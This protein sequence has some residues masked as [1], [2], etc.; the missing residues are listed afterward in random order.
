MGV[1]VIPLV[2]SK[3]DS[4]KQ[5]GKELK[6]DR[7]KELKDLNKR[8]GLKRHAA[9]LTETPNGP[10]AVVLHEG[11]GADTFL[12]KLAASTNDF[13]VW[14]AGKVQEYHGI[15]LKQPPTGHAPELF[16]DSTD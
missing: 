4:W 12:E 5:W 14:F 10:A 16:L 13:D 7:A 6:A 3:L 2:E 8:Y 15:D 1:M 9:W 11:P